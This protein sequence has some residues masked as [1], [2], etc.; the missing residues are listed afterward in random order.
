MWQLKLMTLDLHAR[1]LYPGFL[2]PAKYVL[3]STCIFLVI[4]VAADR[5]V[6][7]RVEWMS[8]NVIKY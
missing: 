1:S 3:M 8:D 6:T 2:H 5:S 4:A 7:G